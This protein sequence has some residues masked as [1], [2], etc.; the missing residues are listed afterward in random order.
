MHNRI[1]GPSDL[2]PES[3]QLTGDFLSATLGPNKKTGSAHEA[4]APGTGAAG[5]DVGLQLG[6]VPQPIEGLRVNFVS[7]VPILLGHSDLFP[8]K[9]KKDTLRGT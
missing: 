5:F 2:D 3:L 1:A 8:H 6:E 4:L 9:T 7:Q